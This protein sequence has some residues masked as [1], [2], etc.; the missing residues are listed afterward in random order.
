MDRIQACELI[1]YRY[2]K[3]IDTVDNEEVLTK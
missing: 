3:M 1:K 2:N